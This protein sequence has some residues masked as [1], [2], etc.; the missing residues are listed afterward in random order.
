MSQARVPVEEFP[1]Q[2]QRNAF[3]PRD[4]ARAGDL[5][6]LC[7]DIAVLGSSRRGWPPER[8]RVE[9]CAFVV[10]SMVAI[11]HRETAFGEALTARTWVSSFKRG[12][13]SDRQIR[14]STAQG[15]VLSATQR[16]VH[17]LLPE[18]KAGRA[19][20]ELEQSF[21][22]FQAPGDGDVALPEHA[23][24]QG[25]EHRF[26]FEAWFT[27]MDPLAHA[28]HPLYV[29]WADEAT[30][31]IAAS[32]GLDPHGLVPL[33][34]EVTWRSG[35][36]APEQVTVTTQLAGATEQGVVLRHRFE[37][38]DGR[39]CAEATLIRTFAD[40]RT[41]RLIEAFQTAR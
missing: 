7:Q 12:T 27:W 9:Q 8:Y 4:V 5:W 3:S 36:I 22:L 25:P 28:N 34:G 35:V 33:A 15:P 13:M 20:P 10:R 19:K 38:A 37:G 30:S 32:A 1:V 39:L 31:R 29:D 23:P 40:Q 21:G 26:T 18:L 11:H 14:V 24:L 17:V 6:R 16:W 2:L 41:D